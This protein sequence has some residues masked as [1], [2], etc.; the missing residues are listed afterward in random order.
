MNCI[1]QLVEQ[2][3]PAASKLYKIGLS[4]GV[5]GGRLFIRIPIILNKKKVRHIVLRSKKYVIIIVVTIGGRQMKWAIIAAGNI[6]HQFATDSSEVEGIEIVAV[7]TRNKEKGEAFAKEFNIKSVYTDYNQMIENEEIDNIYIGAP[8]TAHKEIANI[9]L[10]SGKNVLCEKPLGVNKK[11]VLS[12]I[13]TAKKNNCLL[14]EAMWTFFFPAAA[15]AK[16]LV[17]SKHFG[18][19]NSMTGSIG[20]GS[21]GTHDRW[22]YLNNMAGGALLDIGIYPIHFFL[23]M[24]ESMPTKL[25]GLADVKDGIDRT[26]MV[27]MDFDSAIASFNASMINTLPSGYD[28]YCEKGSIHLNHTTSP[29]ILTLRPFDGKEEIIDCS[30]PKG[31][32]QYE[33][34]AF[35]D[36]SKAGKKEVQMVSYDKTI[37]AVEVMDSLRK[38]WNLSYPADK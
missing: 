23:H 27:A 18:K 4:V 19:I 11:E 13:K 3:I 26:D 31:G 25:I 16:E 30:F 9:F 32:M 21:G 10:E 35:E 33:I 34:Q 36:A 17:D 1:V 14:M 24:F 6:S 20:Y 2:I 29:S 8:H 28:I 7:C 22:K 5:Q 37:K 12:M 15:K 38:K